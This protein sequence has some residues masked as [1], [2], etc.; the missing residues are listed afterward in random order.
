MEVDQIN[1]SLFPVCRQRSY[2]VDSAVYR[3]RLHLHRDRECDPGAAGRYEV[4]AVSEGNHRS[5]RRSLHDGT[6]R[7]I[8]VN[9]VDFVSDIGI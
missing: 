2:V 8:R 4:L 3:R 7:G 6:H 9:I 1:V 5:T